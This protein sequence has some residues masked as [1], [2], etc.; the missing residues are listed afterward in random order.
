[1]SADA[2][3]E[4]VGVA[5]RFVRSAEEARDLAQDAVVIALARGFGDDWAAAERRGWLR[6][7]VRKRAAFVARGEARRRRREALVEGSR[8]GAR[9]WGWSAEFL[10]SLPRSVRAVAALASAD[11][12]AAEIRWLLRLSDA[13]LRQRLS[14]LRRA[15]RAA[16]ES[17]TVAVGEG[18]FGLGGR[19][20]ALL[21]QL[22]RHGGRALVTH[23]PDG[24]AIFLRVGPHKPGP[25]GNS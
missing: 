12:C 7:V 18:S 10:A 14:V 2:Y 21:A 24:H 1:M 3:R 25:L 17:A 19:R 13:A 11:L 22:R 23:D 6:G 5:R 20:A 4:L 8:E 15:V 9:R 16:A